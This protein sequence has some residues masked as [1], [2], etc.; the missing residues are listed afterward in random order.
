MSA[1]NL[2]LRVL[3]PLEIIAAGQSIPLGGKKQR[4]VLALLVLNVNQWVTADRFASDLWGGNAPPGAAIT[5]RSY[6]SHVRK[7]LRSAE[8][9]SEV[10]LRL[11]SAAHGYRLDAPA[12]TV[13]HVRFERLV[14]EGRTALDARGYEAAR[15]T[16]QEALDLWRGAA[17]ADVAFAA[18]AAPHV[19]RLEE[20]RLT[21]LHEKFDAELAL[22]LHLETVGE[23]Q[24]LTDEHPVRER[25]REQLM[26]ALYRCG[27]Q[28][29]ALAVY[30]AG[31]KR[32][33]EELGIEPT[34]SIRRLQQAILEHDPALMPQPESGEPS[35]AAGATSRGATGRVL[36]APLQ[37]ATSSPFAGRSEE[38][39]KLAK[40]WFRAVR[41]E[42]R[43][44]VLT[45]EAGAGK[46]TLA[47]HFAAGLDLR[48]ATVLFGRTE[49]EAL[50]SYQPFSEALRGHVADWS[51]ETLRTRLGNHVTDLARLIPVLAR[52]LPDVDH[53][54]VTQGAEAD[55]YRLFEA[56]V[57]LLRDA[58]AEGPVLLVIDDIHLADKSTALML[59]HV[60][61]HA[62]PCALLVLTAYRDGELPSTNTIAAL[63]TDLARE[64][65]AEVVTVAG[66]VENELDTLVR[67][68]TGQ[69]PDSAFLH[70]LSS[71]TDGN[72]FFVREV[73]AQL[74]E[75][76]RAI[77]SAD[78]AVTGVPHT[79]KMMIRRRLQRLGPSATE[80]LAAGS[81]M[82]REFDAI[83][84][85]RAL[86][87][88]VPEVAEVMDAAAAAQFVVE[89]R[90]R[91]GRYAFTHALVQETLHDE[92][93]AVRRAG[94]HARIGEALEAVPSA[95]VD[96]HLVELA[97]NFF[98]AGPLG[99][100]GKAARY[101]VEAGDQARAKLAYEE[102]VLHYGRALTALDWGQPDEATRCEL[103]LRLA[104]AQSYAGD[105]AAALSIYQEAAGRARSAG[106]PQL[107]AKA[108]LGFG[109]EFGF[110]S[111]NDILIE[112]LQGA[113][114]GLSAA[115]TSLRALVL[116]RLAGAL[117]WG[118]PGEWRGHRQRITRMC[119]EAVTLARST[120]DKS[121]LVVV[122][123][124]V[125]FAQWGPDNLEQRRQL[126]D[127][128]VAVAQ[129]VEDRILEAQGTRWRVINH[130]ELGDFDAFDAEVAR[131]ADLV[132]Q[133][134]L[135]IHQYWAGFWQATRALMRGDFAEAEELS[136]AALAVGLTLRSPPS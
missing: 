134:R 12:D 18:F 94:M 72:P 52:S 83:V 38:L 26:L 81:L 66:L 47:A 124:N 96:N 93:S 3:G 101:S 127:E 23:L 42:T 4:A 107:S 116:S 9:R 6:L 65:V 82:G 61:H 74:H 27:R 90:A 24:R 2:E 91:M 67:M 8:D 70:D 14:T 87:R 69:V 19:A 89:L 92:L 99:P 36:P 60:L 62:E 104:D 30:Q 128:I 16:L 78:L 115:D 58:A 45:G 22:G 136:S 73:L 129:E 85:A 29:E 48:G 86:R 125:C 102:A 120:G 54:V 114:D 79:V 88:S 51:P 80:T 41:G 43:M 1:L 123:Q 98:E 15:R 34:P 110:G 135:P 108:A 39:S 44:V 77:R 33:I 118:R 49:E 57:A 21:A 11:S 106:L 97:R 130:A 50:I 5:V 40:A 31:R 71:Q 119:A 7:I 113:L 95:T 112:L 32:L 121:N 35:R 17:L 84:V 55:R 117:Y 46:S 37:R 100:D 20:R 126:A 13:D 76:G 53:R 75:S 56:V 68:A 132:D 28:S 64:G 133:L 122:L 103:M 25:F 109:S 10:S 105:T 111:V 63:F 131:Y 59:R